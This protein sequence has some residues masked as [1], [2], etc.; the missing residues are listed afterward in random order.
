MNK[1]CIWCDKELTGRQ[2]KFCSIVCKNTNH[3]TKWRKRTKELVVEEAGG[4]CSHCGY[5][6][7]INA[8]E[9]HHIDPNNKID[10]IASLISKAR[11]IKMIRE[12][13]SKCILLCSNCHKE[14]QYYNQP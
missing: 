10:S 7:C 9:F 6:K 12:E 3:V 8:L 4:C 5:D 14:E 11:P 1:K 13:A 2:L